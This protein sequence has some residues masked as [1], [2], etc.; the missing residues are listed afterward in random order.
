[1]RTDHD[2]LPPWRVDSSEIIIDRPWLRVR[3]ERVTLA[4]GTS[5]AEFHV[6]ESPSWAAALALTADGQAVIVAQY[7][8]GARGTS[9]EL[10]AGVIDPSEEPLAAARRELLEE[11]GYE[12]DEWEHLLT[13]NTEPS[14]HTSQAWFFVAKNARRAGAPRQEATEDIEVRTVTFA[15][16][17]SLALDGG[18]RHGVHVGAIL[19]AAARGLLPVSLPSGSPPGSGPDVLHAQPQS[20]APGANVSGDRR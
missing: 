19:T 14:R 4:R 12:S 20:L 18:V 16:L 15:Q 8:H 7:R 9:V 3:Q 1:M 13:V 10:P 5:I 2:N 6:I 17:V 11:T